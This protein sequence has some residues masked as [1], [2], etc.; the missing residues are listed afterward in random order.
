MVQRDRA[1][2]VLFRDVPQLKEF[3]K[4]PYHGKISNKL[5]G[6]FGLTRH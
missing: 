2:I 6:C 3:M 5:L 4:S 1:R